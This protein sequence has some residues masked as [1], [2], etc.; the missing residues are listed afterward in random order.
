MRDRTDQASIAAR[1]SRVFA[2][3]AASI[4]CCSLVTY[5]TRV[6][7][8][9]VRA[10]QH[11]RGGGHI[12]ATPPVET[13]FDGPLRAAVCDAALAGRG[14]PA[15]G[16]VVLSTSAGRAELVEDLAVQRAELTTDLD[17]AVVVLY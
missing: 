3:S 13:A 11:G 4:R 14:Y 17:S 5:A 10:P 12:V 6:S 1:S 2:F 16:R 8:V 9:V 15:G 7:R